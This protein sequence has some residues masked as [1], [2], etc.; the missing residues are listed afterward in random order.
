MCTSV[1]EG[2]YPGKVFVDDPDNPKSALLTTFIEDP[3]RGIWGFL[4]GIPEDK[5][6]NHALNA[7][8]FNRIVV[9]PGSPAL[10][11][12]CDPDDWDG[13]MP[14]VMA[15]RPPIWMP[16][17]HFTSRQLS[18]D[19]QSALPEGF[20]VEPMESSL[21]ERANL[22]VPD[23]VRTTIEKWLSVEHPNFQDY[24]FITLD[25]NSIKPIIAGW[26]TVDFIAKG[27]GDLGFFTQPEYRRKSLGTIAAAAT[28]EHGFKSGLTQI[29]WTCDAY[30]QGSIHTAKKLGLE[31]IEDYRIALLVMDE[32]EHFANL[33]Y[34][35]LQV[36]NYPL[37]AGSF[38]NALT[39]APESPNFIYFEAAQVYAIVGEHRKAVEHLKQAV[40]RGWTNV[41]QARKCQ[42]FTSLHSYPEWEMLIEKMEAVN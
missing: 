13:R 28:L 9:P 3:N 40:E 11:L 7:S 15:P 12:T 17:W 32:A 29:N 20:A 31:R 1:L 42:A 10:L 14:V 41:A 6:F 33:G 24:G 18:F 37:A 25:G 2:I 21:L 16:R 8:I 19:W 30:N 39:L 34:Y 36:E 22:E 5:G 4:A 27:A 35:A 23:D 26:A 38:D